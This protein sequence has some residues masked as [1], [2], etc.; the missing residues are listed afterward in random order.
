MPA[1]LVRLPQ[2][3]ACD[4]A[5]GA[6]WAVFL[7][8]AFW[9]LVLNLYGMNDPSPVSLRPPSAEKLALAQ[10]AFT[11]FYTRCFWFLREDLIVDKD[12]LELVIRGLRA[13]GNREAFLVA[14]QLCR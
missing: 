9:H 3:L 6:L 4:A 11:R 12:N 5:P 13:H 2:T 14:A 1:G 8:L 10:R 7:L